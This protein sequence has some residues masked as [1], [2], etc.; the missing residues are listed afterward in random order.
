MFNPT[1]QSF[2]L[3][4]H[5]EGAYGFLANVVR[6]RTQPGQDSEHAS[7]LSNGQQIHVLAEVLEQAPSFSYGVPDSLVKSEK[8]PLRMVYHKMLRL[9]SAD[10][11]N[12]GCI[13]Q[14]SLDKIP[15][16]SYIVSM[17]IELW[18]GTGHEL[19]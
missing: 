16:A 8:L 1:P 9:Y 5:L 14:E 10:F 7:L 4:R 2:R 15:G 12:D 18:R 6:F 19:L 17:R 3:R 13:L 11:A